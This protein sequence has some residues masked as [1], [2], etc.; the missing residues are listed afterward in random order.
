MKSG[1]SVGRAL[2]AALSISA[3]CMGA[4]VG[5]GSDGSSNT[6]TGV[7]WALWAQPEASAPRTAEVASATSAVRPAQATR[8]VAI[9]AL[10][11]RCA[12]AVA[13]IPILIRQTAAPAATRVR[14]GSSVRR[15]SADSP[16]AAVRLCALTSV[17][18]PR[19]TRRTVALAA[20]RAR[21]ARSVRLALAA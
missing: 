11:R 19:M 1:I 5:C 7:V 10:A 17:S 6:A 3:L 9:P 20:T 13:P 15:A 14:L 8:A 18:I 21:R 16:A 12:A 2:G 4:A